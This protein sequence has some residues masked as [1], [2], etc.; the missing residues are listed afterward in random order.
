M[1]KVHNYLLPQRLQD[2]F[3][4]RDS[5]Y[6]LRGS[7]IYQKPQVRTGLKN[8]CVSVRGVQLW[9]S[10]NKDL[11]CSNSIHSFKKIFKANVM[12]KYIALE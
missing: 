11:K 1:Y 8:R 5:S 7:S 2:K 4:L 9:N 6:D 3:K 12:E 10:L